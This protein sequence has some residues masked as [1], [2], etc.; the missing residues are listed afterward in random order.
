MRAPSAG[1]SRPGASGR[2]RSPSAT[3]TPPAA[4]LTTPTAYISVTRPSQGT[5]TKPAA[6]APRKAP[7][8]LNAYT[9]AWK[10]VAS[11]SPRASACVRIG[12]VP[13][14]RIEGG[15]ISSTA[16]RTSNAKPTPVVPCGTQDEIAWMPE[17]SHGKASA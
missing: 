4:M 5:R 2:A 7:S 8:V 11:S 3:K 15:P 17:N 13:P 9:S 1:A 14:M 12:I 10:R 16:R 6:S